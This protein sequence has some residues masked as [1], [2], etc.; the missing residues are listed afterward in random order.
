MLRTANNYAHTSQ[1]SS[2]MKH[3]S[4]SMPALIYSF[5]F[6][7]KIIHIAPLHTIASISNIQKSFYSLET[8]K[9]IVDYNN[10]CFTISVSYKRL[11][12]PMQCQPVAAF[13]MKASIS[14]ICRVYMTIKQ[15]TNLHG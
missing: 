1:Q 6:L 15:E 12:G 14:F 5:C 7:D 3:S 10:V 2:P 8:Y 4:K 13:S 11:S 9:T